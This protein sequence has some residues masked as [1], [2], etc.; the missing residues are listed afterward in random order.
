V[1]VPYNYAY[2][3]VPVPGLQRLIIDV[4]VSNDYYFEWANGVS[5]TAPIALNFEPPQEY[6]WTNI[7]ALGEWYS[8]NGYRARITLGANGQQRTYT[9]YGDPLDIGKLVYTP[10]LL[11]VHMARGSDTSVESF[12]DFS[13]SKAD[14]INSVIMTN[15]N[16]SLGIS[17]A[18]ISTRNNLPRQFYRATTW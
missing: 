1:N 18:Q 17:N 8:T 4:G 14:V 12:T 13:V 3:V 7:L 16:W 5:Y 10:S 6:I 15:F 11:T 2:A 9:Q